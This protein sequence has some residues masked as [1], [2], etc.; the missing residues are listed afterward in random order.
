[1]DIVSSARNEGAIAWHENRWIGDSSD[2]GMFSS[3]HPVLVFQAGEY[4]NDVPRPSGPCQSMQV[5]LVSG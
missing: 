4:L 3:S 5:Q 1:M 2:D